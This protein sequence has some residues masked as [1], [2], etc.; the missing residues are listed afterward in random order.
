MTR[1][2]ERIGV[3]KAGRVLQVDSMSE[4]L[5]NSLWNVLLQLYED[6]KDRY[7]K[8]AAD[9]IARFFRKVPADDLPYQ[10]HKLREWVKAYFFG[11][12]WHEVYD[13]V[14][15]IVDNHRGMTTISY[16]E[17]YSQ[18]VPHRVNTDR[19]IAMFNATLERE[20]SGFRFVQAVLSPITDPVEMEAIEEAA[21]ASRKAGLHGAQ[22]HIET[23]VE[24]LGKRPEPDYRNAIK[25]AISAVESVVRMM[26]GSASVDAALKALASKVDI[27]KALRAGF[28][29]L[30][31]FTSDGDGIRHAIMDQPTVGFPEAKYMI[32]A[33]SAFVHYLIAKGEEAGLL[34]G[35]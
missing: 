33:C 19:L 11:L 35:G 14:E 27:H 13:L 22:K 24:L 34:K 4:S 1:F 28:S 20:L 5:R 30:Y 31:G 2:S 32:V 16:G 23:A 8:R 26:T 7:W 12:S 9:Y 10:D 18:A 21:E 6:D 25:E 17:G 29:N 15:F 3:V